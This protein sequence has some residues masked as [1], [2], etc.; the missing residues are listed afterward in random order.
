MDLSITTTRD[1]RA[2]QLRNWAAAILAENPGLSADPADGWRFAKLA[3]DASFRRYFRLQRERQ[4]WV[5]M[6]APPA[7]EDVRP[8]IAVA[9]GLAQLGIRVPRVLAADL[10]QGFLL[11]DDL[12]DRLYLGELTA[13]DPQ[14]VDQLYQAA[15]QPLLR[16]QSVSE[17]PG[18]KLPPYDRTL[19]HSELRLF[20]QWF[21]AELLGVE[22][23]QSEQRMLHQLYD[24]LIELAL[25][26]PQCP[27]HRDYH[28]RNLLLCADGMVGVIDFQDAVI[29]PITYDLVS[30]LKDCYLFWPPQQVS[31]WVTQYHRLA[32][33]AA[34][35]SEVSPEQFLHWFDWIGVQR[36]LKVLGIFSRL[37]LRDGKEGYLADLPRVARHLL[38]GCAPH[39]PLQPF[40]QWF[41]ERLLPRMA[42]H[43]RL[44]AVSVQAVVDE[45]TE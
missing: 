4:S 12:G 33:N 22:L 6:D 26:Q 18:C 40:A 13:A 44:D 29:G 24:E 28:S 31:R 36:H 39:G 30:L 2:L 23:T 25:A 41:R 1:A 21:I 11:L 27:V 43:P 7:K 5:L 37:F 32:Q 17:L 8:F 10:D 9:G 19:L 45:K 15:F 42:T 3:G 14:R 16:L 35:L 38:A 20:D 34:L